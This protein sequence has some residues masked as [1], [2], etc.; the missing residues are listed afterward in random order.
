MT[1]FTNGKKVR[2]LMLGAAL[3]LL[4]ST[5]CMADML[6]GGYDDTEGSMMS[7]MMSM[8][9]LESG[10]WATAR[11]MDG[12]D[13]DAEWLGPYQGPQG[14]LVTGKGTA[15]GAPDI[16]VISLGVESVED[17]AA[18]ART[19]AASA[20]TAV[21]DVLSQA[22][23]AS[24]D[25][26]TRY[27]NISPRYRNVRVTRCLDEPPAPATPEA[28]KVPSCWEDWEE[29]LTG[30]AVTNQVSVKVRNLENTGTII[31]Q[32]T[33]A[34][35]DL[36]RVNSVS[37]DH[38]DPGELQDEA[39][40]NA[41]ADMQRKAEMMAELS[42]VKLGRLASLSEANAYIPPSPVYERAV[43]LSEGADV[44]TSISGG[45]LEFTATVQGVYLIGKPERKAASD[46]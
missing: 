7:S 24:Q 10:G 23:I 32:V 44:L 33:D 35:G 20:M 36:I 30:Y 38:Q 4:L 21:M 42:G 2:F 9:N 29:I 31:D 8:T 26:Q 1:K 17:T 25:I 43:A 41:V 28:E 18:E 19:N 15:S 6:M 12:K 46:P 39:L 45:E 22:E 13:W 40:D 34:A 11:A 5:A 16:A 27:F 14:L 37:F 3:A